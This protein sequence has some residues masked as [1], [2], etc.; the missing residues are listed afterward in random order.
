MRIRALL[1]HVCITCLVVAASQTIPTYC[2][3]GTAQVDGAQQVQSDKP[4]DTAASAEQPSSAKKVTTPAEDPCVSANDPKSL[5]TIYPMALELR[6]LH[7]KDTWQQD[8]PQIVVNAQD[9]SI[10]W[11]EPGDKVYKLIQPGFVPTTSI[12]EKV[13]LRICGLHFGS[14]VTTTPTSQA[15]PDGAPE[16]YSPQGTLAV[17]STPSPLDFVAPIQIQSQHPPP[18]TPPP[19]K[20]LTCPTDIEESG[21][22]IIKDATAVLGSLAK[23]VDSVNSYHDSEEDKALASVDSGSLSVDQLEKDLTVAEATASKE[24]SANGNSVTLF[25]QLLSQTQNAANEAATLAK[26]FAAATQGPKWK[27]LVKNAKQLDTAEKTLAADVSNVPSSCPILKRGDV[28]RALNPLPADQ[29]GIYGDVK[30]SAT[31]IIQDLSDSNGRLID[32]FADLNNYYSASSVTQLR[33]LDLPSGNSLTTIS[34]SF[35]DPWIPFVLPKPVTPASP[36]G[37]TASGGA[38]TDKPETSDTVISIDRSKADTSKVT[39]VTIASPKQTAA[40][41]TATDT[42][43]T[44]DAPAPVIAISPESSSPVS[45]QIS[46]SPPDKS[47]NPSSGTPKGSPS[48]K[49]AATPAS[50][51]LPDVTVLMERHHIVHFLATGGLLLQPR[52]SENYALETFPTTVTTTTT[53]VTTPPSSTSSTGTPTPPYTTITYASAAGTDSFAYRSDNQLLH[54]GAVLGVTFFPLGLDTFSV[55]KLDKKGRFDTLA[56]YSHSLFNVNKI[57]LFMGTTV[58]ALGTFVGAVAYEITPGVEFYAGISNLPSSRLT[59]GVVACTGPGSATIP[60]TVTLPQQSDSAGDTISETIATSTV[61]GCAN[62]NA[63]VISSTAVPTQAYNKIAPA[64][65]IL[66]NSNLFKALGLTK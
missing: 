50:V 48:T 20:T 29:L 60:T 45:I 3:T 46:S 12:T 27:A 25:N 43:G 55:T 5:L 1:C 11:F 21:K 51:S 56:Y 35:A 42:S 31:K 33:L 52:T 15:I 40:P 58:N 65:G 30:D 19:G 54:P 63:T 4:H 59:S 16:L 64:F 9:G 18:P 38:E 41:S 37:A 36:F 24:N 49:P 8:Y 26:D 23:F 14:K 22:K 66:L 39:T 53:T 47:S 44:P 28:A 57:G 7:F 6:R 34:I 13:L 62:S 10:Y 2:Q 32:L 61:T 17:Q